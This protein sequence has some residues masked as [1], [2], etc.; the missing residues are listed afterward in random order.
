MNSALGNLVVSLVAETAQYTAALTQAQAQTAQSMA[1]I[2]NEVKGMSSAVAAASRMAGAALVAL[3][4]AAVG[5]EVFAAGKEI[6]HFATQLEDLADS[7]GSSVESLSKI[8]NQARIAGVDMAT[9]TPAINKLA[10]GMAGADENT[11][12]V[13][14]ALDALGISTRDPA[15]AMQEIAIKLDGYADGVGK[16]ALARDLF[17]KGGPAF[18][19]LL[20]DM[21]KYQDV[22]ATVTAQ[23]AEEA[24]KLEAQMRL[25]GVQST[26]FANIVLTAVVPAISSVIERFNAGEKA[27]LG[28]WTAL[29]MAGHADVAGQIQIIG[30]EIAVTEKKITDAATD[31]RRAY[32]LEQYKQEKRDL[33][34][35]RA[36]L[37]G[38]RDAA[39]LANAAENT[40]QNDRKLVKPTLQ[41]TGGNDKAAVDAVGNALAAMDDS[42]RRALAS[43]EKLTEVD[44]VF[45]ALAEGKI[46]AIGR[47]HKAR[48]DVIL[49]LAQEIDKRRELAAR[50]KE[51]LQGMGDIADALKEEMKIRIALAE[52]NNKAFD[53]YFDG[54][55]KKRLAVEGSIKAIRENVEAAEF[56]VQTM[57]LS[58]TERVKAI[59]LREAEK[60]HIDSTTAS[61][62]AL[63]AR[64]QDATA[65]KEALEAQVALWHGIEGAA[66]DAWMHIGDN[67][68]DTIQRIED[69]LKNGL[70]ELLYQMT[71]K[72]F[73][74]NIGAALTGNGALAAEAAKSGGLGGLGGIG[75]GVFGNMGLMTG[76]FGA[77]GGILGAAGGFGGAQTAALDSAL[78]NGGLD[79]LAGGTLTATLGPL[80]A[81][82]PW[83]ALAAIA[84]PMIVSAFDDGPANRTADFASGSGLGSGNPAYRGRSAFGTFGLQHDSYFS[85]A[86]MGPQLST[87][88]QTIAGLD[89]AIASAVGPQRTADIAAALAAH[90]ASFGFGTEH[91]DLNASGAIGAILK[92]RYSVV[93]ATLDTRLGAVFDRFE[94]TGEE[95]GKFLVSLIQLDK[96]VDKLPNAIGDKLIGALDGTADSLEHIGAIATGLQSVTDLMNRDPSADALAALAAQ[97]RTAYDAFLATADALRTQIDA[98]D[99]STAGINALTTATN[100]YYSAQ[101]ALLAQIE[102]VRQ[103]VSSMFDDTIR[104]LTLTTL[105]PQGQYNFLQSEAD[106]LRDQLLASNDPQR[107]EALA[108]KINDDINAAFGLLDPETQ[109]SLLA[110]YTANVNDLNDLV[111]QRLNEIRD[112]TTESVGDTL[113]EVSDKLVAMVD[114]LQ[115]AGTTQVQAAN[116]QLIAA[117]TPLTVRVDT[118]AAN[119]LLPG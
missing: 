73:I 89:N 63:I 67:A 36:A 79:S 112:T 115:Q 12:H 85:D 72:P 87:A 76:G 65:T 84:V 6:V 91:T 77:S 14:H 18:L 50:D 3:P 86:E 111:A 64:M 90:S 21:A 78:I 95:M 47:E 59:M 39:L 81:A 66:H 24:K 110:Q 28:F 104:S 116:T 17:G 117:Q 31:P 20:K 70:L 26:T 57:Q 38:V 22:A 2:S 74:L 30:N 94:G 55:E 83:V 107:I 80:I 100:A 10:A 56:E 25:L 5:T 1:A 101:V 103:S 7:T 82:M 27:G 61:Y 13:A 35:K 46:D 9:L 29:N 15:Q 41:Y 97:N 118:P 8:A 42:L 37:I 62:Q 106:A 114:Q 51:F 11:G 96:V 93:L 53:E 33:E 44:K 75:G 19:S 60:G 99:E 119:E 32:Y 113:R 92:D 68:R 4:L 52:A 43:E 105:D 54:E 69:A 34:A 40:D 88:I 98:N 49:G 48:L 58:N 102:Q 71:A 109:R 45:V 16:A 108:S 23:Q